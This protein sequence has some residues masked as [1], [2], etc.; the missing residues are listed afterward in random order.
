MCTD[1][2]LRA[3]EDACDKYKVS[4]ALVPPSFTYTYVNYCD[5]YSSYIISVWGAV[6][7][8]RNRNQKNSTCLSGFIVLGQV[9]L[10]TPFMN[11]YDNG[12]DMENSSG[13][14]V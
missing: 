7:R 1:L 5:H 11:S 9:F 6:L 13:F 10:I 2:S 3:I 14:Q 12:L 4:A 8:D